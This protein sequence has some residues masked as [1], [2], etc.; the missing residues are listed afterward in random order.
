MIAM[1]C[2]SGITKACGNTRLVIRT[3]SRAA[4]IS[5]SAVSRSPCSEGST[6]ICGRKHSRITRVIGIPEP[7]DALRNCLP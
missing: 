4:S 2:D 3:C 6:E 7:D 1:S 5:R